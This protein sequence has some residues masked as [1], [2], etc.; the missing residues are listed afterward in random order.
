MVKPV[1]C[2]DVN[3]GREM[4]DIRPGEAMGGVAM[5]NMARYAVAVAVL[6]LPAAAVGQVVR[7]QAGQLLDA[8]YQIGGGGRNRR[9]QPGGISSQLY[10][11]GQV[12]G[13][14][15][16]QGSVGYY[17]NNQLRL[18]LPSANLSTFRG[19]SVGLRNVLQGGSYRT[20]FYYDPASTVLGSSWIGAGYNAPG[21]SRPRADSAIPL[22]AKRLY[23]DAM[24]KYEPLVSRE[25]GRGMSASPLIPPW[26]K[27]V[28][29]SAGRSNMLVTR[30]G[31]E[32]IFGVPG[33][34]ERVK[35]ARELYEMEHREEQLDER[36]DAQVDSR[37][38]TRIDGQVGSEPLIELP[39]PAGK[40]DTEDSATIQPKGP[41]TAPVAPLK[42]LPEPGQDIFLDVLLQL[43][44]HRRSQ[45]VPEVPSTDVD[46][47]PDKT[48]PIRPTKPFS[49]VEAGKSGVVIR[50]LAGKRSNLFNKYMKKAQKKLREGRY[51]AAA[52]DFELACVADVS[53]PLA[54]IGLCLAYFCAGEPLTAAG[55]LQQAMQ[56]FP[57]LMETRVEISNMVTDMNFFAQRLDRLSA[58][59]D[60][61]SRRREP[62][63]VLLAVFSH[64]NTGRTVPAQLYAKKLRELAGADELLKAYAAF[65]LPDERPANPATPT[66]SPSTAESSR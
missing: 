55:N 38:D 45:T 14:S 44:K 40:E 27:A 3:T 58:R 21:T 10:V 63:L 20:G 26:S 33:A 13:L 25:P 8:N 37:V 15:G 41:T 18:N 42:K 29:T 39:A 28:P 4:V 22:T 50:A 64:H 49:L 6:I 1:G 62:L 52:G 43:D 61:S 48:F 60:D 54:R 9:V 46:G 31:I 30:P 47:E 19:Q 51:Y 23:M 57:P 7:T 66:T 5:G 16:F 24:S 56:M 11:T 12:T 36:L 2:A 53:N 59:L 35:L 32:A 17:A 34:K 65:I